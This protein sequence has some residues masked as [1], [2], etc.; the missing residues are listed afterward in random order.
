MAF[1]MTRAGLAMMTNQSCVP[2]NVVIDVIVHRIANEVFKSAA[3]EKTNYSCDI[4]TEDV[5]QMMERLLKMFPDCSFTIQGNVSEGLSNM[6][7]R[8]L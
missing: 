6:E 3:Q 7:I 4:N 1:P 8:W 2:K 5:A